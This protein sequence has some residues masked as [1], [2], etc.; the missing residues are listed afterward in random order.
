MASSSV[1]QSRRKAGWNVV[2]HAGKSPAHFAGI[3]SPADCKFLTFEDVVREMRLCFEFQSAIDSDNF[4]NSM[5]FGLLDSNSYT[6]PCPPFVQKLDIPVP[7]LPSPDLKRPNI[8]RFRVVR[9]T[10][11]DLP[12]GLPLAAHLNG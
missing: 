8:L 4:W 12:D 10:Q 11:C 2:F 7:S 5:A 3:Y 1:T 9:H 6:G